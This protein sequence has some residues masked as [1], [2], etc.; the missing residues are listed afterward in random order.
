MH[1]RDQPIPSVGLRR[2]RLA[3]TLGAAATLW[4]AISAP[5][6]AGESGFSTSKRFGAG[7]DVNTKPNPEETGLPLYPGATIERERRHDDDGVNLNLW[8]GSYGLRVVVVKLK[9]EDDP[10]KVESFYR[11]ALKPYGEVLD[12]SEPH[13]RARGEAG[14]TAERKAAKRSKTLTCRDTYFNKS[15]NRD[16]KFFKAG[17]RD[18]Q[19]GFSVQADG[20]GSTMQLFQ[21]EKRGWS[22]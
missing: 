3:A 9:S 20:S 2:I 12:C 1:H 13:E 11:D 18:K 22:D 17:T 5:A 21:L 8:F 10:A 7:I 4:L 6:I 14:A 19:H 15:P 16:G